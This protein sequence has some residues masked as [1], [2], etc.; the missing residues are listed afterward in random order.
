MDLIQI[1]LYFIFAF[2]LFLILNFCKKLE[3]KTPSIMVLLP[4]IYILLI[5]S[6]SFLYKDTIYLVILFEML[7]RIYHTKVI[8]NQSNLDIRYYQR[9]YGLSILLG[10]FVTNFFLTKVDTIFLTVEEMRIGIWLW[11]GFFLYKILNSNL[12]F[13][14]EKSQKEKEDLEEETVVVQYA[15]LKTRYFSI[16]KTTNQEL[17]LLFYAMMIY[18]DYHRSNFMRKLDRIRFRF[19]GRT[20]KLGIMQVETNQEISDV[21]SIKLAWKKLN[22]LEKEIALDQSIKKQNKNQEILMAYYEKE[23]KIPE[24]L[25]IDT[26]LK[27]FYHH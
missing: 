8:L 16:L 3:E 1:F 4:V 7:I 5:S 6:F 20:M 9:T 11:I 21:E 22:K 17:Q 15:K 2:F 23:E 10:F 12:S 13:S 18:E 25:R 24:I 26:I 19:T 27:E 14:F